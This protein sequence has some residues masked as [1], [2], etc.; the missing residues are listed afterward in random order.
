MTEKV[1]IYLL[2]ICLL[3]HSTN[4]ML[5]GGSSSKP[6][7]DEILQTSRDMIR[8][9]GGHKLFESIEKSTLVYYA[10]QVVAGTNHYMVWKEENDEYVCTVVWE[11]LPEN[12]VRNLELT[13]N[14]RSGLLSNACKKCGAG[15]GENQRICEGQNLSEDSL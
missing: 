12:G 3:I 4:S 13:E 10:T 7:T 14:G 5:M 11:K 1:I 15:F 2:S 9:T 8:K 6:V